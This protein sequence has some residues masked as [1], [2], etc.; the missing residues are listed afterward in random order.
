MK[1]RHVVSLLLLVIA[2][3]LLCLGMARAAGALAMA[4]TL[5]E[6]FADALTGKQRNG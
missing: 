5:V 1:A 3:A 6:L 2:L 4:A